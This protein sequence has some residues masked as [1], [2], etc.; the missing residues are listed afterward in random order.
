MNSAASPSTLEQ[1]FDLLEPTTERLLRDADG[2]SDETLSATAAE[3]LDVV[4][5]LEDVLGTIDLERFPA[6]VD[7]AALVDLVDP[8]GI[9]AAIRERDLDLALDFG[10]IRRAIVLRELWNSVD[11]LAFRNETAQLR[12]ELEDV[13]DL[14]ALEGTGGES[15]AMADLEAFV[16]EITPDARRAAIQQQAIKGIEPAR[17]A[18]LEDH[19]ALEDLYASKQRGT[20]YAGRRPVSKNPTAVSTVPYGPLPAGV[21]TRVSTV[22]ANVRGTNVDPLPRVYARRWPGGRPTRR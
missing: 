13:V 6:A 3:L 4:A 11:L 8:A 5:A 22:P 20:G 7:T 14:S 12:A 15:Q 18:A 16:D 17:N 9:P 1:L 10:T 19:A 21:S 2:E